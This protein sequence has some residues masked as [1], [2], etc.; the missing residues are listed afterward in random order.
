MRDV[1]GVDVRK[2]HSLD[3]ER[4]R[5]VNVKNDRLSET[6][7]GSLQEISTKLLRPFLKSSSG[8]C[9]EKAFIW[10]LPLS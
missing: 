4:E 2:L 7:E 5:S 6:A 10:R 1:S 3:G 9:S 8:L